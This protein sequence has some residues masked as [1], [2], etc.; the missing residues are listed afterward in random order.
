MKTDSW[1]LALVYFLSSYYGILTILF[2]SLYYFCGQD[3]CKR[4]KYCARNQSVF[5]GV[6]RIYLGD[7][8]GMISPLYNLCI[9]VCMPGF[10]LTNIF[11]ERLISQGHYLS[12]FFIIRHLSF[13]EHSWMAD[14][15]EERYNCSLTVNKSI[16]LRSFLSLALRNRRSLYYLLNS[17]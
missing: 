10:Y 1:F 16:R 17:F 14:K 2:F 4:R 12:L 13:L 6:S 9:F 8:P 11:A 5:S 7:N 3:S 15:E